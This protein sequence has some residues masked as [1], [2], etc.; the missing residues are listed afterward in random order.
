MGDYQHFLASKSPVAPEVGFEVAPE[1][2]NH[3]L[4]PWQRD[5]VSW[6]LGKGR[7]ALLCDTG[8]GKTLMQLEWAR[9]VHEE[10]GGDVLILAPL[11]VGAQTA[12]EGEKFGIEVA[13]CKGGEDVR[14]GVNVTNYERLE[15]F[16]PSAFAGVVLD[17]A[18]ILKAYMGK[19]KRRLVEAFAASRF[20]LACTA[21]PAPN[22]HL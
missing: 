12:R 8:T 18:S 13:R 2:L 17:E 14:P 6:A 5:I 9:R 19:T 3:A 15:A 11:A 7:A 16:D 10:T 1:D 21:T 22:D 4:F 20:R